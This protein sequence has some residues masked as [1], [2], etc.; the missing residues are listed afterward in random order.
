MLFI[1]W[2]ED[3]PLHAERVHQII[4]AITRR[5]DTLCTSVFTLGE[6]LTGPYKQS[7]NDAVAHIR[8]AIGPPA[9]ELIPLN[10]DTADLYARIRAR[11][12]VS[13][14][15]AIHLAAAAHTGVNLFLTNDEPLQRLVIPGIDFIA[16]LNVNLF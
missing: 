2:L 11:N 4:N 8:K 6:V 14:A 12:R 10:A 13:P 5:G 9:V 3:H 1:Y 16:G 7:A 15:D